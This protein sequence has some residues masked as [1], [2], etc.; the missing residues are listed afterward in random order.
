MK[1]SQSNRLNISGSFNKHICDVFYC[2]HL[3]GSSGNIE[4]C[5]LLCPPYCKQTNSVSFGSKCFCLKRTAMFQRLRSKKLRAGQ[6]IDNQTQDSGFKPKT[7]GL[8]DQ[9]SNLRTRI[10]C[11]S[12]SSQVFIFTLTK[13]SLQLAGVLLRKLGALAIWSVNLK[14]SLVSFDICSP[15]Y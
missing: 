15:K 12:Y 1:T 6:P 9:C 3:D 10:G 14:L 8:R 7:S 13:S 2:K 11:C 5:C 4:S